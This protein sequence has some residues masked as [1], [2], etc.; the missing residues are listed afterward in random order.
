MPSRTKKSGVS[1]RCPLRAPVVHLRATGDYDDD[2]ARFSYSFDGR[3][4][5][6]IGEPVRLPYQLKTFQ[7]TRYAL[8]AF[9]ASGHEG[10]HADLFAQLGPQRLVV[11][12][13]GLDG[14]TYRGR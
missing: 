13:I 12:A 4:F 10:G 7:G 14:F 11:A 9:N 3:S 8:F 5:E 6:E 1:R 2:L